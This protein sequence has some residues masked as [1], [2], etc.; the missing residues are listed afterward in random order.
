MKHFVHQLCASLSFGLVLLGLLP[1]LTGRDV[2]AAPVPPTTCDDYCRNRV[3]PFQKYPSDAST[4]CYYYSK[5]ACNTCQAG[6][7]MCYGAYEPTQQFCVAKLNDKG[8]PDSMN[9]I[10]IVAGPSGNP[11]CTNPCDKV[12][13]SYAATWERSRYTD[14]VDG[15]PIAIGWFICSASQ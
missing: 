10:P 8:Q 1:L 2:G 3:G 15:L 9:W 13:G 11:P 12:A 7:Y 5:E 14:G 4:I 6:G